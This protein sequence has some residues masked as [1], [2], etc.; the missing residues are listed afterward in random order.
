MR[1]TILGS[2]LSAA[3][4]SREWDMKQECAWPAVLMWVANLWLCLLE[5]LPGC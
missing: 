1:H 3:H 4:A 2:K 5:F